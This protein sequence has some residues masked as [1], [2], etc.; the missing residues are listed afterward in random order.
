MAAPKGE[1][2]RNNGATDGSLLA[3]LETLNSLNAGRHSVCD[4]VLVLLLAPS[5]LH[6]LLVLPQAMV[7]VVP[8][9]LDDGA[10]NCAAIAA[11]YF[12]VL[13]KC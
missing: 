7:D 4:A 10:H 5:Q 3:A 6:H 12:C 8:V 2:K 9:G 13:T 1:E 11:F